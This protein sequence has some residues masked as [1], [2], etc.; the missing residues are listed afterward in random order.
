MKFISNTKQFNNIQQ[1]FGVERETHLKYLG[2]T[3]YKKS[4]E[5]LNE[6]KLNVTKNLHFLSSRIFHT[7]HRV[8]IIL[9]NTHNS[10]LMLYHYTQMLE[11]DLINLNKIDQIEINLQKKI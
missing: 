4:S 7:P 1:V 2:F 6:A 9:F 8:M 11:A 10:V 3:I 5:I